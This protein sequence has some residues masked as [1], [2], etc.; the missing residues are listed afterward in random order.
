MINWNIKSSLIGGIYN[1]PIAVSNFAHFFIGGLA[2]IKG[3]SSFPSLPY[4][5]WVLATIY[6]A[7]AVLF[8]IIMYKHPVRENKK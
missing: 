6:M 2:L 8:G 5:L 1:R 7:F 3:I 4:A